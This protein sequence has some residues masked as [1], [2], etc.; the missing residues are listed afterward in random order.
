MSIYHLNLNLTQAGSCTDM[1]AGAQIDVKKTKET[2]KR[3]YAHPL[4]HGQARSPTSDRVCANAF[5]LAA[6]VK[7]SVNK[8]CT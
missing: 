1:R 5:S 7:I 2:K 4:T 3:L 8:V 6:A